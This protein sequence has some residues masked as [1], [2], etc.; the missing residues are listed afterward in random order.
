MLSSRKFICSRQSCVNDNSFFGDTH[1]TE[2]RHCIEPA[3]RQDCEESDDVYVKQS[4]QNRR[5]GVALR[6]YRGI[7]V[8][9]VEEPAAFFLGA[10]TTNIAGGHQPGH[11]VEE[12]IVL[13]R[14]HLAY[15]LLL[16]PKHTRKIAKRRSR[17]RIR[18]FGK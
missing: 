7:G 5:L 16:K 4:L 11:R 12:G 14:Q 1:P 8:G 10:A 9:H 15:V 2:A 13:S 18:S 17:R 3:D 6:L